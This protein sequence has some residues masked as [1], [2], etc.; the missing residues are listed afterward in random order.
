[1]GG[2]RR[3][4]HGKYSSIC[5]R[6]C[7]RLL[8]SAE[9]VACLVEGRRS[10]SRS[11]STSTRLQRPVLLAVDQTARPRSASPDS[12][13][14]ER[15]SRLPRRDPCAHKE[16]YR[17]VERV[18]RSSH[19]SRDLGHTAA[20][21]RHVP[22]QHGRQTTRDH[23][24]LILRKLI[25]W[26]FMY[27]LDG[28]LADEGTGRGYPAVRRRPQVLPARPGLQHRVQQRDRRASVPPAPLNPA[29]DM[30]DEWQSGGRHYLS[31]RS[32]AQLKPTRDTCGIA[33]IDGGE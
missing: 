4:K 17:R 25:A 22:Q 30:H 16:P 13:S 15:T 7:S 2:Q 24:L 12:P 27:S 5:A 21:D 14:S 6:A 18:T 11:I 29:A 8:E 32:M 23:G 3:C 20:R 31:E 33:A 19:Y 9:R 10:A 28:L 26:V 1:M